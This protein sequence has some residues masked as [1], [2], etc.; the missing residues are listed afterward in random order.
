MTIHDVPDAVAFQERA[1][2]NNTFLYVKIPEV[3]A[4][5]SYKVGRQGK[6]FDLNKCQSIYIIMISVRW[7]AKGRA[8]TST[9]GSLYTL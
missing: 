9:N 3:Q 7:V 4:R 8:L 1:A 6:G 5:V 2:K